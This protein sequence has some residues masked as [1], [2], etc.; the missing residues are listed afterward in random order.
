MTSLPAC[1]ASLVLL[2]N[3][4]QHGNPLEG[5]YANDAGRRTALP[6]SGLPGFS[7]PLFFGVLS[8]LFSFGRG[9]VFFAPGLFARYPP[10]AS[11]DD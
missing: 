5:G 11:S 3:A 2:E 1:A 6:Y 10:Q 7:Y 8:V 4:V 9:L